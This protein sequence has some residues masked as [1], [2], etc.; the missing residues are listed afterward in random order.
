MNSI[1]LNSITSIVENILTTFQK[2][3]DAK[4]EIK[5]D[6]S[7]WQTRKIL[8][9]VSP[10][11]RKSKFNNYTFQQYIFSKVDKKI[12]GKEG[13]SGEVISLNASDFAI[14]KSWNLNF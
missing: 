3:V 6:D 11:F 13:D 12:I 10:V 4:Y 14:L 2:E 8:T 5:T 9:N 1:N 7:L